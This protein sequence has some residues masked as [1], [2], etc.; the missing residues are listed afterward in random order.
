MWAR[1]GREPRAVC[2]PDMNP[3]WVIWMFAGGLAWIVALALATG[4]AE[5]RAGCARCGYDLTGLN[6]GGPCPECGNSPASRRPVRRVGFGAVVVTAIAVGCLTLC[7]LLSQP[8]GVA[9]LG[10]LVASLPLMVIAAVVIAISRYGR[11]TRSGLAA[12]CSMIPILGISAPLILA[13]L[14]NDPHAHLV[15]YSPWFAAPV[16]GGIGLLVG[17]T[18]DYVWPWS[19]R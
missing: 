2:W 19:D 3:L 4:P 18:I 9:L 5:P 11:V 16:Y 1:L 6:A 15:F 14:Y 17:V 13:S 12:A 8:V 7:A 10:A